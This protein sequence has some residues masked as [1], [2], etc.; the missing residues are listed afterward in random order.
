M[1]ALLKLMLQTWNNLDLEDLDEASDVYVR[2]GT[3][4]CA[5]LFVGF[6]CFPLK[7]LELG[8]WHRKQYFNSG[9]GISTKYI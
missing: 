1:E 8:C 9:S 4:T 5:P 3:L 7:H 6:L 2:V